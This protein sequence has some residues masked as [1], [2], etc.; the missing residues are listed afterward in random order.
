MAVPMGFLQ[1]WVFSVI[2]KILPKAGARGQRHEWEWG[3]CHERGS[4]P[5]TFGVPRLNKEV[6]GDRHLTAA[7]GHSQ[8]N[9]NPGTHMVYPVSGTARTVGNVHLPGSLRPS[10]GGRPLLAWQ[11]FSRLG[12]GTGAGSPR[13]L[14]GALGLAREAIH[15]WSVASW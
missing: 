13:W 11:N 12:R 7:S 9:L 3:G 15:A 8:P 5:G 2:P 10:R 1:G 14:G 6:S 4:M